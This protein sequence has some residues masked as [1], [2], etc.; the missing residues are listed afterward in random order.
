[1]K[2]QKYPNTV[3]KV[4]AILYSASVEELENNGYSLRI[5]EHEVRS[6]RAGKGNDDG[7]IRTRYVYLIQR[8]DGV[9]WKKKSSKHGD[10]GWDHSVQD[11]MRSRFPVGDDLPVGMYTTKLAALRHAKFF[12]TQTRLRFVKWAKEENKS[13]DE[14]LVSV[15]KRIAIIDR[16]INRQK[17][18]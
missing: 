10:Y 3:I 4:G 12:A 13:Y 9:T 11:W 15:D 16:A 5:S 17:A 6:I 2:A 1:L 14:I 18:R 7:K 8:L